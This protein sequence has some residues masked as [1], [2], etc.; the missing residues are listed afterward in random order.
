MSLR[1][2]V[3]L[4]LFVSLALVV[5]LGYAIQRFLILP[6]LNPL[7]EDVALED[8]K[9]FVQGIE[10]Q[11]QRLDALCKEWS[12]DPAF[13]A[14][15]ETKDQALIAS[16]LGA[17]ALLKHA[18]SLA[19]VL[20]PERNL[21]WAKSVDLASREEVRI[22]GLDA[23]SWPSDHALLGG[24][25]GE[26]LHGAYLTNLGPAL[27]S[28]WPVT[29]SADTP[30]TGRL[31]L[32]RMVDDH[33][34]SGHLGAGASGVR[35]FPIGDP[36]LS[37]E[38]RSVI[39]TLLGTD[40]EP[41]TQTS[42]KQFRV[43][44]AYRDIFGK[45]SLLLR[46]TTFRNVLAKA[47]SS[48]ESGLLVQVG[49][50]LTA[51][52]VLIVTFRRTIMNP[53]SRLTRH[54]IAVAETNDLSVRIDMDRGDEIGTLAHEFDRMV[55]QLEGDRRRQK[56]DEEKLRESEE[57]YVLAVQGANDGLWDWDLKSNQVHFSTRWKS[58]LGF[59][60]E[61]I[62]YEIEEWFRRIH[63]E[64]VEN[65]RAA[66]EAHLKAQ[67]AHFESEHRMMHR[68]DTYLWMLCRGLA[69]RDED[70]EATR[71]AG[72]LTDI[73]V[74]KAFE[75]QISHQALHDSLTALP[76]RSLFLDRLSQSLKHARRS[77]EYMF[78]VLF[79]DLD[80]FKVINDG[81]GHVVG[82]R[83]LATVAERLAT[84]VRATDTVSTGAGTLARFG[85]D[86]FVIL[87]DGVKSVADVTLVGE[88]IQDAFK[89]PFRVDAHEIFTTTSVGIVI[90]E[91]GQQT[92]E[93]VVRD[94][95]TAMYRAKAHGKARFE[96][97]NSDMYT[98]AMV[99]LQLENDLR[100]AID[101]EEF[102]VYYQP[103]VSL[104]SGK[105]E[106]IEALVRWQH[107]ERGLVPPIEFVPI[108]E[109]TGMIIPIGKYVLSTACRQARTWQ[110]KIPQAKDLCIGV[111]LAVNDFSRPELVT[112]I[113][114]VLLDAGLSPS[115][116][117]L[118]ITEGAILENVESVTR[119]LKQMQKMGIQLAI[120]DFGTG[121][122]SLSYLHR[123][124]MDTLKIDRAFVRDMETVPESLQIVK[125]IL[126]LAH[127]LGVKVIAEGVEKE[128]Q[129]KILRDFDCQFGQGYFFSRP[130]D[131]VACGELLASDPK[132]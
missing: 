12:A 101:R 112:E 48:F 50:G 127:A 14:A 49:I 93:E 52:V 118:E 115:S 111:N 35:I 16:R 125:T 73:T 82:D 2:K 8:M 1:V 57:R 66:L 68:S 86:E 120:D 45:P 51:L 42:E 6:A 89:E 25:S 60:E 95:D 20:G 103:I 107:P 38:E 74:R 126:L 64:D 59:D 30:P 102:V 44:A 116:L 90:S 21:I 40:L 105:I 75:E 70:G 84:C 26:A 62:G 24:T 37:P 18:L 28:S 79:L 108:A 96:I 80:R 47:Y 19:Y 55:G 41:V 3:E 23:P 46:S 100:R 94:A 99:R 11:E 76:N 54:A 117:K 9:R 34:F 123:F 83:L 97:F 29:G 113:E 32:G 78:A 65:V 10:G 121:Y 77:K 36:A 43:Y 7:E 17:D 122:S 53:L 124:P 5:G 114:A 58:M 92:P 132:W 106:A 128:N 110:I 31:V 13:I 27:V 98:T 67:S 91:E 69:I 130:I 33:L 4:I 15:V 56:E 88:R 39:Q 129:M 81:L 104:S 63:P 72:S 87:L 131:A 119:A 61:E 85:G 109:E 71:M 22:E